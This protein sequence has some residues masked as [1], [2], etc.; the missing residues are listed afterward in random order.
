[1][2]WRDAHNQRTVFERFSIAGRQAIFVARVEAGRV[3]NP[4]LD[5][6]HLLLG[7]LR[8]AA[9]PAEMFAQPLSV[10]WVREY[11]TRWHTP[12]TKIP[13]STD[14]PV[15]A[16]TNEVFE[17]AVS[18]ADANRCNFVR[19]EHLLL[20]LATVANS[21]SAL[22]LEQAGLSLDRL[23]AMLPGLPAAEQEPENPLA[24]QDLR[25]ELF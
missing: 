10:P 4:F 22:I 5:T 25:E 11:A 17:K 1:V 7:I 8:M 18:L 16:D 21:H 2:C 14:L 19:T 13:T 15:H 24:L 3:G 9:P 20:A 6:E 23:Q 12:T